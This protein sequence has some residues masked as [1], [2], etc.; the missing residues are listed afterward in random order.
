MV[1]KKTM[2]NPYIS[3]ISKAC[4]FAIY[5]IDFPV[6]SFLQWVKSTN[7][8]HIIEYASMLNHTIE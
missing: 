2:E 1:V 7:K 5:D 4:S 6:F 3:Y 8:Y